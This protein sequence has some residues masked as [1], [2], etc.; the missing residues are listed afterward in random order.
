MTRIHQIQIQILRIALS[1]GTMNVARVL[2]LA[3]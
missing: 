3:F 2:T 1:L